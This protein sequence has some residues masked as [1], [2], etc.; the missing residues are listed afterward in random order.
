[1]L[2]DV[3]A[4][5][6]V[7][8]LVVPQGMSYARLAGLPQEYGLYGAFV[9]VMV[10]A[11]LG[12]SRHLVSRGR[13]RER[14]KENQVFFFTI[15]TSSLRFRSHLK[16][17]EKKTRK[18]SISKAVGPV[19]V[20]SMIIGSS[21]PGI[22]SREHPGFRFQS[23]PNKPTDAAGQDRYN[24]AAIQVAFLAGVFY[25]LVGVLRLGFFT[26]FLSHSVISG[27]MTGAATLIG[28]TQMKF[29][30][31]YDSIKN[32]NWSPDSPKSVSAAKKKKTFFF[33]FSRRKKTSSSTS[34]STSLFSPLFL[35][36]SL[37]LLQPQ[38]SGPAVHP[39]PA[40][41]G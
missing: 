24:R 17:P 8:A 34:T 35:S 15:S 37:S 23:D 7:A 3:L 21:L 11:A 30:F 33:H 4:G 20:T 5:A 2:F 38:P 1:M 22:V 14:E 27:F 36:S 16:K 26:N 31:G 39:F 10:Y 9:P 32:K 6:S 25:T 29:F 18:K 19:A 41:P 13:G 12:S 28:L 40:G